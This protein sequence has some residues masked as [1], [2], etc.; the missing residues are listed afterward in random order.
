MGEVPVHS[1]RLLLNAQRLKRLKRDQDRQ[2]VRWMSFAN[3]VQ[4][5]PDSS[6]R[7]FELA[8]YYAVT[9]EEAR[10]REAVAWARAHPCEKRQV[11]LVKDWCSRLIDPSSPLPSCPASTERSPAALRDEL[12][13][14]VT[15]DK[16]TEPEV[17]KDKSTLIKFL[18]SGDFSDASQVYAA[19]EYF[20]VAR[21]V[22]KVDLRE[23]DPKFFSTLPI[24]LLLSLK[25]SEV[26]HPNWM[27]HITA[28][29]LVSLDPNLDSSQF[30]QGWA[31]ENQQTVHDG[32]GLAY[33]FLWANPYLPGV[34]YQ[35]LDSW[36][37]DGSRGLLVGRTNWS[38]T[39]CWIRISPGRIQEEGCPDDWKSKSLTLGRLSLIPMHLP[40]V[41]IPQRTSND[42]A[43]IWKLPP[44]GKVTYME[45]KNQ[46][47]TTADSAGLWRVP[48]NARTQACSGSE[49]APL[50]DKLK[51]SK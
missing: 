43:V 18:R 3:R 39:A 17:E 45:G 35:N 10:G 5:V 20:S 40:C 41:Q 6:E 15:A 19:I 22:E 12:F 48:S 42:N 38:S 16:D 7:G 13:S 44:N 8:L 9:S 4:S 24:E 30:L 25:T 14:S 32:V 28:L 34:G 49:N 1:P 51:N 21:S 47:A 37:Y 36:L 29:A 50:P 27:T 11:A 46:E 33:E 26:E 31:L 2:T 23:D